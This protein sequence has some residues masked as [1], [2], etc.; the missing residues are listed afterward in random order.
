MATVHAFRTL[1]PIILVLY[2]LGVSGIIFFIN[3]VVSFF[4]LMG[5]SV[6]FSLLV[7]LPKLLREYGFYLWVGI[8]MILSYSMFT[9]NGKTPLFFLN[10]QAITYEAT[11]KSIVLAVVVLAVSFWLK[12][13]SLIFTSDKVLFLL[14]KLSTRLGLLCTLSIRFIPLCKTEFKEKQRVLKANGYYQTPSY[15]DRVVRWLKVYWYVVTYTFEHVFLTSAIMRSKG[16][17]YTKKRSHFHLFTFHKKD[18]WFL[19]SMLAL[20][21]CIVLWHQQYLFY[22][23][24]A[25]KPWAMTWYGATVVALYFLLPS[26]YEAKEVTQWHYLQSKM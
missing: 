10:D 19:L 13:Y 5:A 23:Y 6:Y 3:P 8:W 1:H 25:I 21:G 7:G 11:Y 15:T 22:Y 12:C 2:V 4:A 18:G 14:T 9:H 17:G 20:S 26:L 24:P 16:Y